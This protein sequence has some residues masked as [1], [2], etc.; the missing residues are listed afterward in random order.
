MKKKIN[1]Y[2]AALQS[3]GS[4]GVNTLD[5]VYCFP[6]KKERDEWRR[7]IED[8]IGDVTYFDKEMEVEG[9]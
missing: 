7:Q 1:I 3:P 4:F 5:N 6:T 9:L 8:K 2:I